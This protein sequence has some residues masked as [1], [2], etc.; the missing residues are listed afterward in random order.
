[1]R[2]LI[3]VVA[4]VAV[5][6]AAQ[7]P[8]PHKYHVEEEEIECG[9]CHESA[10]TSTMSADDLNP[11]NVICLDCHD[12][13]D[14]RL[15]WPA[16]ERE[17]D[18]N[19]MQH[20]EQLDLECQT[21]HQG[22]DREG[23]RTT[24][25]LPAMDDCMTCHNGMAAPRDCEAC[26]NT[27]RSLLQPSSHILDWTDTH[28]DEVAFDGDASCM[29]CHTVTDCQECHD[30]ALLVER[31]A[32]GASGQALFTAQLEGS[33]NVVDRV[34]GLNFRFLHG[35]EARGKSSD[36]LTCHEIDNGDFC[37]ECHNPAG[38]AGLR[39]AWHGVGNWVTIGVGS[40]G[41][42][43]AQ[44]ARQDIETCAACHG[45]TGED[46]AC[47]LCHMDRTPGIGN[48][49]R[50]HDSDFADLIGEG[51]FHDDDSAMCFTCHTQSTAPDQFC[52]YCH[53]AP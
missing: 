2:S 1:M 5:S 41:G 30:G 33:G 31:M 22:L 38:S 42:E 36:C 27:D 19:H 24:G 23:W 43:H 11:D 21:C 53:E 26:H 45:G 34:H 15:E 14:V 6:A 47:L 51:D 25:Y 4:A 35:I 16:A 20:V 3:F 29:P 50:T 39:P 44:L 13:G 52:S 17:Y 48:D 40:G 18:F 28:G 37:A 32:L 12:E 49:P 10:W 9:D 8:F 46:P 7:P